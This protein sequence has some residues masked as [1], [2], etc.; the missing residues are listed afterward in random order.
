[1]KQQKMKW[2]SVHSIIACCGILSTCCL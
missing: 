2:T 1:M